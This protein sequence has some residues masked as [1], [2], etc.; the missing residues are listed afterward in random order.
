MDSVNALWLGLGIAIGWVGHWLQRRSNSS[1][2]LAAVVGTD[3]LSQVKE[4]LRQTEMAY[5]M[6][7]QISQFKG[8]FLART[9]HEL[10]SPMNGIIGMHQLILADLSDSPEEER[11]FIAQANASALKMIKVLDEVI[12]AAKVEHGTNLLALQPIQL[13]IL[14][15]EV[16]TLTHLQAQNRNLHLT[17]A[18]PDP[19]WYVLADPQRLRQV[20]V[21]LIDS[22]IAQMDEGSIVVAASCMPDSDCCQIQIETTVAASQW[23]DGATQPSTCGHAQP[24]EQLDRAT[25][26]QLANQPFPHPGFVYAI[27]RSLMQSMQG[28]LE[29][30]LNSGNDSTE[31]TQLQC[32]IPYLRPEA[33]VD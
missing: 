15:R 14:L 20:L 6:A 7:L 28:Q 25:V 3:N 30:S 10:R 23:L 5:Q 24:G 4:Q 32:T 12:D 33:S 27:A 13:T 18:D 1:Q 22:A 11:D 9:S 8:S 31:T 26:L 21:S 29:L 17:I 16:H 19:E 2:S